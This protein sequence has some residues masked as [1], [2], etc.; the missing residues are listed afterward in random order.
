LLLK[1]ADAVLLINEPSRDLYRKAYPDID[2]TDPRFH[3]VPNGVDIASF[4]RQW[5]RPAAYGDRP[6]AAYV[7]VA[8][9]DWELVLACAERF[10]GVDFHIA[11]P[12][13]RLDARTLERIGARAN[14]FHCSGIPPDEVPSWVTNCDVSI[15][16]Y[17]EGSY[18][19]VAR[20][21]GK[22]LQS[23]AARRPIVAFNLTAELEEHGV[24]V[25]ADHQQFLQKMARALDDGPRDYPVDLDA[26]DWRP[27]QDAVA[28]RLGLTMVNHGA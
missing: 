2:V 8:P 28:E 14:V 6:V 27:I 16:P 12:D 18:L 19:H 11:I 1:E 24:A 22:L 26:L 3:V 25:A 4:Q 15:V 10:E 17:A 21:H 13:A 5:P 20:L 7:G 23:M 9:V